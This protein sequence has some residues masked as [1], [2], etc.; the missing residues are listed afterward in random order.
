MMSDATHATPAP[1]DHAHDDEHDDGRVHAHVSPLWFM[2]AIFATLIFLTV[3][4]VAV[5]YVDLGSA[6]TFVA[7]LIATM[8]ASLVALF[9]MHLRHDKPFNG[10]I[11]VMSFIFLGI[12]LML[13]YDDLGTR[14]RVTDE[15]GVYRLPSS[16]TDAPGAIEA[17]RAAAGLAT[18]PHAPSFVPLATDPS[19]TLP[20][21]AHH[22]EGEPEAEGHGEHGAG[23]EGE[24]T[25]EHHAPATQGEH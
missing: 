19:H 25:E 18:N 23:A 2:C 7:V 21:V 6:N 4:T 1:H 13:S 3:V 12:F 8:K 17:D 11:F 16:G 24:H 22:V 9:F 15:N 14:G 10:I 20:P 5:S